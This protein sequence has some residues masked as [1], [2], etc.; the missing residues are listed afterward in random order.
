MTLIA[1]CHDSMQK[2]VQENTDTTDLCYGENYEK[3]GC[4]LVPS[5][6]SCSTITSAT[7]TG[8]F[9]YSFAPVADFSICDDFKPG[10][11]CLR[12]RYLLCAQ[13]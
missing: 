11:R 13:N 3:Q 1:S 6:P 5:Y 9:I 2:R 8:K 10:Q 4:V 7:L 12:Q